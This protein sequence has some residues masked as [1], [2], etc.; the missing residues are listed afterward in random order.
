MGR[1]AP[2]IFGCA[3]TGKFDVI[4]LGSKGRGATADMRI[5]SVAQRI[6]AIGR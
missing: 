2:E 5:G 1:A 6:L 3:N 4:V